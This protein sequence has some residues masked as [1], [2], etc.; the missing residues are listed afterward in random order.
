MNGRVTTQKSQSLSENV[1]SQLP[2][3]KDH[4]ISPTSTTHST[5]KLNPTK[6]MNC[7][8]NNLH[9]AENENTSCE[10]RFLFVSWHGKKV[11]K[12]RTQ[13]SI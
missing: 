2:I 3:E 11:L 8:Q 10:I 4:F 12:L 1:P 6:Y 9:D 13:P 7:T 5:L